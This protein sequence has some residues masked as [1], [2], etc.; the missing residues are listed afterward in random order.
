M[1]RRPR[2]S[3]RSP[4]PAASRRRRSGRSWITWPASSRLDWKHDVADEL[5]ARLG[6]EVSVAVELTHD[7]TRQGARVALEMRER[8]LGIV[9]ALIEEELA[10][11]RQPRRE[12][13]R[14]R[15][16]G[17]VGI[18]GIPERRRDEEDA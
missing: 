3:T 4:R 18:V 10:D 1:S 14:Q 12:T 11:G 6:E 5:G 7:G 2:R 8:E 17:D 9:A 13:V 15:V 16:F